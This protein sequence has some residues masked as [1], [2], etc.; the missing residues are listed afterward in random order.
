MTTMKAPQY[1]MTV[2][3]MSGDEKCTF[4]ERCLDCFEE[5]DCGDCYTC[6]ENARRDREFDEEKSTAVPPRTA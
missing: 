5:H 6:R 1:P 2:R 4:V 3:D